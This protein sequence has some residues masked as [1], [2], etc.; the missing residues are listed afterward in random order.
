MTTVRYGTFVLCH[1][2]F[3]LGKRNQTG[4]S[5]T[6]LASNNTSTNSIS[7]LMETSVYK[8]QPSS[9]LSDHSN[10]E[11]IL[12]TH[13]QSR[14]ARRHPMPSDWHIQHGYYFS[15]DDD[16]EVRYVL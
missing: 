16:N 8:H 7:P 9:L 5:G 12:T 1:S 14:G 11:T 4:S 15:D 6:R 10:K 3:C 13:F 2:L